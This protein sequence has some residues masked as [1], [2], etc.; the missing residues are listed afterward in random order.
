MADDNIFKEKGKYYHI[1]IFLIFVCFA[2]WG[3]TANVTSA[4]VQYFSKI[5]MLGVKDSL[6]IQVIYYLGYCL[7]AFPAA[8]FIRI[9]SFKAGVLLGL[10]I[11][12]IGLFMFIP[13]KIS[14]FYYSFLFAYFIMTCGLSCLEVGC[15]TYI[16]TS[17]N[18][19]SSIRRINFAQAFN[20]FGALL[21]MYMAA[22]YVQSRICPLD[23]EA[24][25]KLPTNQ[26]LFIKNYDMG[27]LI[28][29]YIFIGGI[30]I[31][32]AVLIRF[33]NITNIYDDHRGN[34]FQKGI[35]EIFKIREYREG[36]IAQIFYI[37]AQVACWTF[38]IQYATKVFTDE[39]MMESQAIQTAQKYNI[40]AMVL[41][42]CCRFGS[43]WLL[44]YF[45]PE[46]M[47]M[48]SS[49]LATL[50]L[51]G[52]IF[53]TGRDGLY[54]LVLVSAFMSLMYPTIFGISLRQTGK[55]IKLAGAGHVMATVGG[56]L[57]PP[58]QA[59]II[60]KCDNW[61]SFPSTNLSFMIP[62][63][64]FIIVGIYAFRSNKYAPL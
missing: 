8:I 20:P 39:G 30:F 41:Y 16:Y 42:C 11:C 43:T 27:V 56:S 2:L 57:I 6:W 52:A 7:M 25:L 9:H 13:A 1:S 50:A 53:F 24:R 5:F 29:P 17:G 23:I 22:K 26:F 10:A 60:V 21:G 46:K 32:M 61:I 33:F 51:C 54:C 44:K 62:T 19:R 28:R 4:M 40:I 34:S 12:A 63:I 49:I 48:I 59:A 36:V 15:N 64:C 38:I 58:I 35:K 55:N 45:K 18:P 31:I 3:F 47:L 14:G 37:G